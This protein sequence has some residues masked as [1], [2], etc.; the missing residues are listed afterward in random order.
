MKYKVGDFVI[1]QTGIPLRARKGRIFRANKGLYLIE[2]HQPIY[3]WE[4]FL[5]KDIIRL[6]AKQSF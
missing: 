3:S 2:F 5:K 1:V 4:G 6:A